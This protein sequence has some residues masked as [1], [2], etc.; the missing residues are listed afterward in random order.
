MKGR[1]KSHYIM[2]LLDDPYDQCSFCD[3]SGERQQLARIGPTLDV[4]IGYDPRFQRPRVSLP[5]RLACRYLALVDTGASHTCVDADLAPALGLPV[6]QRS[7][8]SGVHGELVVNFHL[9]QLYVTELRV[10]F[11]GIFAAVHLQ[12]G[13]QSH[14]VLLGRSFLQGFL[15]QYEGQAGSVKTIPN[16]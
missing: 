15:M 11:D 8:V 16:D 10:V 6:V 14:V 12:S 4:Q 9:A 13:G 5:N 1:T 3:G 7:P 2:A